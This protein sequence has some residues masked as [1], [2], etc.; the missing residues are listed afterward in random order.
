MIT[1]RAAD[2][3]GAQEQVRLSVC[4]K[5]RSVTIS[6]Y[7]PGNIVNGMTQLVS[8]D[9]DIWIR[10]DVYPEDS[11]SGAI[12]WKSSNAKIAQV[13][14]EKIDF[15]GG[16]TGTVTLTATATDGSK[17][18][19]TV[20]LNVVNRV[21]GVRITNGD[22]NLQAG[23]KMTM[24]AEINPLDATNTKLVWSIRP[25]DAPYATIDQKGVLTAKKVTDVH[26]IRVTVTS[27]ENESASA[28]TNVYLYPAS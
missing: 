26:T 8:R 9:E 16:K 18:S 10:A 1:V 15:S 27:L 22:A 3:A 7:W 13:K 6:L 19:A 4:P 14:G 24:K 5:V 25:E 11:L 21:Y 28:W 12:E 2:G 20:K 17:A 23:K